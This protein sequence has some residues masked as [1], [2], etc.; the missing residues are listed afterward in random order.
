M[1]LDIVAR[2]GGRGL[3]VNADSLPL[4]KGVFVHR[5]KR[6]DG[7][8]DSHDL[9]LRA[10]D[11][12]RRR[13]VRRE[14]AHERENAGSQRAC[15]KRGGASRKGPRFDGNMPLGWG[16]LPALGALLSEQEEA[17]CLRRPLRIGFL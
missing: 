6:V 1:R 2:T 7:V 5:R 12:L 3:Q 13:L 8:V 16:R 17:E 9:E 11:W 14:G 10:R 15:S 4:G